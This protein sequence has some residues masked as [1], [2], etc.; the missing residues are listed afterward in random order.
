LAALGRTVV[1]IVVKA[2]NL[3]DQSEIR[4]F[5]VSQAEFEANHCQDEYEKLKSQKITFLADTFIN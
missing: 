3:F 2:L 5:K 4:E 1:V